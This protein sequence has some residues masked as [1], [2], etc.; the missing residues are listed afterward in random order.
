MG[1]FIICGRCGHR[2]S[3]D[4][5]SCMGRYRSG[6]NKGSRC[7]V[8]NL[9]R[10]RDKSYGVD[11]RINGKRHREEV[12]S[13]R[14]I[15]EERLLEL[16]ILS[17][18]PQISIKKKSGIS[19]GYLLDWYS[20][21]ESFKSK[22]SYRRGCVRI[23]SLRRILGNESLVS[24]ITIR[25]LELYVSKR[26]SEDSPMKT[27]EKIAP[28]TVKEELNLLRSIINK[29]H[30]FGEIEEIPLKGYLYPKIE[31]DNIRQRIFTKSEIE[32]ILEISPIWM[33]NII[34]MAYMTGMRQR[35]II[36]LQW[37][38]VDLKRGFIRLKAS[39]TKTRTARLVK[40][41]PEVI[42]MLVG[43]RRSSETRN[44]F[45]SKNNKPIPYWT[46]YCGDTWRSILR[47]AGVEN[48][49]FHD[50]RHDFITRAIRNGTR[51]YVVMKQVG[52]KTDEML[53]RYQL[54]DETDLEELK[55]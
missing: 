38:S 37:D 19:I 42:E 23:K 10:S 31:V 5:E 43:I 30:D 52:H 1:L 45:L 29:A 33:R 3:L 15:A 13:S 7:T 36:G 49:C 6:L 18:K 40:L 8:K 34:L 35:E 24:E 39:E 50:L 25:S 14:V 17:E 2:N 11:L 44:V 12:G 28:K 20:D 54:I 22:A 51:P 53:R 48:A 55:I 16:S 46:T 21:L 26:S 41:V 4:A 47:K 32:L 27:G 9:K